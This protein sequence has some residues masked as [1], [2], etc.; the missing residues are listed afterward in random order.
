M[1]LCLWQVVLLHFCLHHRRAAADFRPLSHLF[2]PA[3]S[4]LGALFRRC[5]V[6]SLAVRAPC[7]V[8]LT[9]FR[10]LATALNCALVF[11]SLMFATADEAFRLFY[12]LAE[13]VAATAAHA[14]AALTSLPE[15][16]RFM[17]SSAKG[18]SFRHNGV[19]CLLALHSQDQRRPLDRP[20]LVTF[21]QCFALDPSRCIRQLLAC[22]QF[23]LFS[24]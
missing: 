7:R 15:P 17:S 2:L 13:V 3:S 9:W 4:P 11:A 22:H 6:W 16:L 12:A 19:C 18:Q 8:V 21:T 14:H 23:Y 20:V 5:L 24:C 10:S 1:V